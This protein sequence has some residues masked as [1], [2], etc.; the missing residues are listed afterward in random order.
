MAPKHH[1]NLKVDDF[2]NAHMANDVNDII[3]DA[4]EDITGKRY[5][6]RTGKPDR[7]KG[8]RKEV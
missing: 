4:I 7:F 8:L 2:A 5:T 3:E 1:I 6:P